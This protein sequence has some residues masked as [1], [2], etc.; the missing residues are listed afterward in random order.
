MRARFRLRGDGR[1]AFR[2]EAPMHEIAARGP[3]R[4]ILELA[5][6]MHGLARKVTLTVP[7]PAPMNWQSRHQQTR[8]WI[9][10]ASTL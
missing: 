2:A 4:V 5:L 1:S 8:T 10:S 9:G 3:A 7:L 6:D